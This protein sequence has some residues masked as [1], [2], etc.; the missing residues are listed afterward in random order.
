MNGPGL[1]LHLLGLFQGDRYALRLR[2]WAD[3][4][5]ATHHWP[6]EKA[7][8]RYGGEGVSSGAS[9]E[10]RTR[11]EAPRGLGVHGSVP[12]ESERAVQRELRGARQRADRTS[13]KMRQN[14]SPPAM[15]R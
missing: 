8:R 7:D 13:P 2:G 1:R 12:G 3:H 6:A 15:R 5:S 9:L 11:L 4:L 10:R 14:T